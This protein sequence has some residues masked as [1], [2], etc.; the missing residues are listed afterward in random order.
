MLVAMTRIC[1]S[2]G[3]TVG[4]ALVPSLGA[5]SMIAVDLWAALFSL[6]TTVAYSVVPTD[7]AN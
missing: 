6:R 2:I 7:G 1:L 4:L 3:V 5:P